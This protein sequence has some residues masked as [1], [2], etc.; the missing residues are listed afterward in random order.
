MKAPDLNA[1]VILQM[2]GNSY[3]LD[4]TFELN[5][6]KNFQIKLLSNESETVHLSYDI[7]AQK[8]T[9]DRTQSGNVAFHEKFPSVES[10]TVPPV[11]GELKLNIF[12]DNSI[13][14]IFA[15][16]GAAVLTDLVYPTKKNGEVVIGL[17]S[18]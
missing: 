10:M 8:L 17:V 18:E 13:V 16:D 4:L 12:V 5:E 11:N 7:A 6:A 9:L 14:E 15:N 3:R 2:D 1:G